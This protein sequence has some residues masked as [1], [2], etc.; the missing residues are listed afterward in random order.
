VDTESET[1]MVTDRGKAEEGTNNAGDAA[2]FT[3]KPD[4][5]AEKSAE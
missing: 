5:A 3:V 1:E 2:E 4:V